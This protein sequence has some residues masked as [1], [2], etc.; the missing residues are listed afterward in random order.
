MS[1]NY[2]TDSQ[3]ASLTFT[4]ILETINGSLPPCAVDFDLDMTGYFA[5]SLI[6]MFNV[7]G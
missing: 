3:I 1:S 7:R 2:F 6:L 4:G 5:K